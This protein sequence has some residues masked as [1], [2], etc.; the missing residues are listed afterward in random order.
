MIVSVDWLR[1]Y[2]AVDMPLDK[3]T[4]ELTMSGLNL[5]DVEP[6]NGDTAI[7]LEVTSNRPDCLGH[8][9]VAREIG[10]LFD[11][12]LTIPAAEV[13]TGSGNIADVTSIAIECEDIC[14]Q[15]TARVIK[16]VKVGPSP[17]WLV[18]RLEAAH[19]D[20]KEN[21][22]K[23][24]SINNVVDITNYVMLECGQPLHAFDFDKLDENRI[25]VR[26][27]KKGEKIAAIDQKEYEL[28]D[29]M[30]VI[31]DASKPVAI[32]GVMGGLET[33]IS[34][35]TTDVLVEVAAFAPLSVRRTART[36]KLFSPSSF[37]FE[38][39]VDRRQ[40]DWASRRCCELILQLAGGTLVEGVAMAG[41]EAAEKREPVSMRFNQVPRIVG[42]DV[43]AD[44][45]TSILNKL[46]LKTV[47]VTADE[48]TFEP[49]SWRRDLTR[50]CDLVEEVARIYGY[51]NIPDDATLPVVSTARSKVD[52]VTDRVRDCLVSLGF[53]DC[54]TLSFVSADQTQYFNPRGLTD[55][56]SVDH[57][58]RREE[59]ILRAS[60]VPSLLVC[61]R[62]NERHGTANAELFELAR[63]YLAADSETDE[64]KVEPITIGGVSGRPLLAG[65]TNDL[66]GVI[67]ALAQSVNRSAVVT[68]KPSD[69]PQFETGRG[70]EIYLNGQLWGWA[71]ELSSDVIS[72]TKL[73]D[74]A[75]AFE[76][77]LEPLLAIADLEPMY[78]VLPEFPSVA[79]DLNFVLDESVSW[80]QVSECV[81]ANG[82]ELLDSV[83][84]GGQYRGK[85][86]E[87]GKK[88]YVVTNRFRSADR[89]LTS[90]EVEAAQQN[91]IA[92]CEKQLGASLRA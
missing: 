17:D 32:G 10:V 25:V 44:E 8:I 66:K 60:L 69:V 80:E 79:R 82:G 37:R 92:A 62:D 15:Y 77:M 76:L 71:G 28:D 55:F 83:S 81:A 74:G 29:Q 49:P 59:N 40:L 35:S 50:E 61:R 13:P 47:K 78:S 52:R 33:E 90:E 19:W 4:H 1:E 84:F 24:K 18:K 20:Y 56:V 64:T 30:C 68:T 12:E 16:G 89:T 6:A 45:S 38:R 31:C 23:Y 51:E 14:P 46:G 67:E 22:T 54:V 73:R 26:R 27:A 21:C 39:T 58:T 85:G 9:G 11:K 86:I 63:V 87:L 53:F 3:L 91:I 57:S 2:V 34:D 36:L 65:D 72:K 88:S 7:D 70:A 41:S 5:E 48:G 42:I 75:S 43:A